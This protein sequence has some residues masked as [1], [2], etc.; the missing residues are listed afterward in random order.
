[1]GSVARPR[2]MKMGRNSDSSLHGAS[3]SFYL[4]R[5]DLA[6]FSP[7]LIKSV[8]YAINPKDAKSTAPHPKPLDDTPVDGQI[9]PDV[10]L[11]VT[12]QSPDQDGKIHHSIYLLR[13]RGGF[14][15]VPGALLRVPELGHAGRNA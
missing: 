12:D 8:M 4:E 15:Q 9:L 14:A 10:A 1:M 2:W 3:L 11:F 6:G 7:G 5:F 13:L